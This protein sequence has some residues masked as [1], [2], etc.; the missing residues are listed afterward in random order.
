MLRKAKNYLFDP[1]YRFLVNCSLGFY[2]DMP[3]REYLRRVYKARLGKELRL[4]NPVTFN[5]KLQWL[6]LNDSRPEYRLMADKAEAKKYVASIIGEEYIVPTIGVYNSLDEVDF[7]VLPDR[8]VLKC[9]HDSGGL[10]ICEGKAS[11]DTA[12]AKKTLRHFLARDYFTQWR[13]WQYKD[14]PHRLIAEEYI[15]ADGGLADYKIHCFNGE[16]RLIL[17]CRDRFASTGLTED[18][19]TE[20]WEHL[21]VR[22]PEHP[23]SSGRIEKPAQLGEMLRLARELARDIPFVRIDFYIANEKILFSE[24]TLYPASGLTAFVPDSWDRTFGDW[25]D[26]KAIPHN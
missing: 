9:T 5:E 11:F 6:K 26:L 1:D 7:N 20:T 15:E 4:E 16:P 21:D 25:L 23:N 2:R 17:V 19:F 3:D 13:E 8:F 12:K 24:I 10:V 18:F 14:L 22:R